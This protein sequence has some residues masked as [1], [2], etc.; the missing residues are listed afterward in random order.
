M[1]NDS[2]YRTDEYGKDILNNFLNLILVEEKSKKIENAIEQ[3]DE[4]DWRSILY[5]GEKE[6]KLSLRVAI[7]HHKEH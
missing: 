1:G 2:L 7:E 3:S 4:M 6:E 5:Y